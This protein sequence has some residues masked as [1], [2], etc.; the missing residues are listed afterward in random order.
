MSHLSDFFLEGSGRGGLIDHD[1]LRRVKSFLSEDV[2]LL[3]NIR[4]EEVNRASE[5]LP[6]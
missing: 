1:A 5:R 6:E 4:P 3:F 2:S